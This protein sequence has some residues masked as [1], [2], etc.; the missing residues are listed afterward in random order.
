MWKARSPSSVWWISWSTWTTAVLLL[1]LA[2]RHHFA[3][4]RCLCTKPFF[5]RQKQIC[6]DCMKRAVSLS[7]THVRRPASCATYVWCAPLQHFR[8]N[9]LK[10]NHLYAIYWPTD[11]HSVKTA[12]STSSATL[13]LNVDATTHSTAISQCISS[14]V[15]SISCH[16]R[17]FPVDEI[18]AQLYL[19]IRLHHHLEKTHAQPSHD[20]HK[21]S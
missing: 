20:G 8:L 17:I 19:K 5:E 16:W 14:K 9:Y 12:L 7:L 2:T 1:L 13:G 6:L 11:C 18:V 4:K 3:F 10:I 15:C 21:Q